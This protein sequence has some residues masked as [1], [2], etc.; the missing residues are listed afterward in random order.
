MDL[1]DFSDVA[2]NYDNYLNELGGNYTGFE[3]FYI[4]LAEKYGG[5]GIIDIACGTGALVIPLAQRGFDISAFDLSAA[6]VEETNKKLKAEGLIATT[7]IANMIDFR[8]NRKY[9]LAII[10]R[11]GFMHLLTPKEQR[12]ALLNIKKHLTVGGILT[13]NTFEPNPKLQAIQM[14]TTSEDYTF[15]AEFIN[16]EGRRERIYNAIG[17]NPQTQIM[18]GNWKFETL[19]EN[20]NVVD[21]RIRPLAMRQTYRTEL[22]YLCELCGYRIINIRPKYGGLIWILEVL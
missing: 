18:S 10:A 8:T 6:M 22:E 12:Q 3:D 1:H 14:D 15:R 21:I 4:S 20:D 11:S 7:F 17:Y 16:S 5:K 2:M 9:S 19:D 13:L